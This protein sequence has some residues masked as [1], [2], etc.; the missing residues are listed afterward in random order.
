M[1]T[2]ANPGQYD[3]YDKAADDE[4]MFTLLARDPL[5]P[6][7]VDLWAQLRKEERGDGPKVVEAELC[8]KE[9]RHWKQ[10]QEAGESVQD[11]I[12]QALKETSD[13]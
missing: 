2:K 6:I 7:L 11:R 8:A 9:M 12:R 3:C 13:G 5:A 4:P 10:K 1:G